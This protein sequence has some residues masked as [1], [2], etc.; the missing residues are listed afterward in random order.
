MPRLPLR[1]LLACASLM[2]ASLPA[3]AEMPKIIVAAVASERVDFSLYFP[4]RGEA[5]LHALML[6]QNRPGSPQ[7]HRWLTPAAFDQSFGPT[8]DTLARV[9][10]ELASRGLV[11]TL[12]RG[13]MLRVT[14]SAGDVEAAFGIVL[15]H[16]QFSDGSTALV[17]DRM[18][19]MTPEL[20]AA[21]ALTPDFTTVAPMKKDSHNLG[22]I[23]NNFESTT[24]PYYAA[25]LRQAYD[26]PSALTLTA[27][28]VQI[29]ILMEGGYSTTDMADYFGD[30][31]LPGS[32][33]PSIS[34]VLVNGGLAYSA[35]NSGETELDIQQ[36]GGISLQA[37]ITL[38]N[39]SDLKFTTIAYGLNQI[40]SDNLADVVNMSFGGPEADL[41]PANNGGVS[42]EYLVKVEDILFEQGTS[43]G[44]TFVASSGDH[45]AIPLAGTSGKPT[46]TPETPATDPYV[47]AVGGTNLVTSF[48]AGSNNSAYVS[49]NA[50]FDNEANGEVWAS[51]G[52]ISL[53]WSKPS[54]QSLVKTPST[55]RRT[56]PDV[57]QHMGGCPSDATKCH[58]PHS[59]DV[60]VLG[61]EQDGVIGTSASSPDIVGLFALKV[62]LTGGRLGWENVDIYTRAEAQDAG[63]AATP[64]HHKNIPGNNGHYLTALPYDLVIGNGS[65]DARQLLGTTLPAAGVPGTSS[66]P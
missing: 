13:Q 6:A 5:A 33:Q 17:A 63:G 2:A 10:A 59:A 52:G 64:F 11:V 20:A 29:G 19:V 3:S 18:P 55:T 66:N 62:K 60:E 41:L 37:S 30:E 49:E 28:G 40:V 25:D 50:N 56:V 26:F 39:L 61:G 53:F 8:A 44:I 1:A 36:S 31:L 47:V 7:Y 4:P 42:Q 14:G 22:P 21:G 48:K 65:V 43:Q 23:P 32:L 45:G 12:H 58:T 27:K 46:L 35:K 16:A 24:G 38:Y 54:Y 51:G 9:N 15:S 34:E 57:A